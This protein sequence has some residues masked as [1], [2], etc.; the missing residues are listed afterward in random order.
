MR[1][2]ALS[3]VLLL[4]ISVAVPVG[5]K[6]PKAAVTYATVK[7]IF[8]RNC[9]SCHS[10]PKPAHGLDLSTYAK[11]M[12]GDKEGKVVIRGKPKM[13]RMIKAIRRMGATPMPPLK[14]LPPRSVQTIEEWVDEGCPND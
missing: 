1:F 12:K 9:V 8:Q 3:G 2:L 4:V 10:G 6:D 5:R 11:I 14:A 7:P 13:S